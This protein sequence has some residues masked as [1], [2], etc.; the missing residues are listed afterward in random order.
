M[1][2]MVFRPKTKKN[3]MRDLV[4]IMGVFMGGYLLTMGL[5]YVVLSLFSKREDRGLIE[6]MKVS[7]TAKNGN[8]RIQE[9]E[10]SGKMKFANG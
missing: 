1:Y 3:D 7:G 8:D 10:K 4:T 9:M 5:L 2:G 6:L